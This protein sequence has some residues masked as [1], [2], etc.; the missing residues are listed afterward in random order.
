MSKTRYLAKPPRKITEITRDTIETTPRKITEITRDT[1]ETPPRKNKKIT[2]ITRNMIEFVQ[3]LNEET[4]G[5]L[6]KLFT[7]FGPMA[8]LYTV[9]QIIKKIENQRNIYKFSKEMDEIEEKIKEDDTSSDEK[10]EFFKHLEAMNLS[11]FQFAGKNYVDISELRKE[12]GGEFTT[13]VNGPQNT[14]HGIP[15]MEPLGTASHD[16]P[17]VARKLSVSPCT[18]A[19]STPAT[20]PTTTPSKPRQTRNSFSAKYTTDEAIIYNLNIRANLATRLEELINILLKS[21]EQT[22]TPL[23]LAHLKHALKYNK[24][25]KNEFGRRRTRVISKRRRSIRKK[26]SKRRKSNRKRLSKRIS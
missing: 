14:G 22:G 12:Y 20:S 7:M 21:A 11:Y 25:G 9:Q 6:N 24:S 17:N 8:G 10:K 19:S 18:T 13:P 1:I 16:K 2:G 4:G 23:T 5:F 15:P 26:F 3:E